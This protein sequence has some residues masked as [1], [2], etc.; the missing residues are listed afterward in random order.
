LSKADAPEYLIGFN[1]F[2]LLERPAL[3]EGDRFTMALGEPVF[4]LSQHEYGYEVD[5]EYNNP[6]GR[7][8]MT[9]VKEQLTG[10]G[11]WQPRSDPIF[12]A[13][14]HDDPE[15]LECARLAQASLPELVARFRSEFEFG[16][17]L[18]KVRVEERQ[19]HAFLWLRLEDI[20]DDRFQASVFEAPPEFPSLQQ[21]TVLEVPYEDVRDWAQIRHGALVGGYSLRLQRSK[22]AE[23]DRQYFDRYS[24]FACYSPLDEFT[25][26]GSLPSTG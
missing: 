13:F 10:Q 4:A 1:Q 12:M 24:G 6:H 19:E 16:T 18:I 2:N 17:F 3:R 20:A 5:H 26:A 11:V 7:W 25:P 9:P 22:V 15:M 23:N 21:G 14:K 8:H